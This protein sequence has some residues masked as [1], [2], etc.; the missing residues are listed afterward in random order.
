MNL[1]ELNDRLFIRSPSSSAGKHK[2]HD[3]HHHGSGSSKRKSGALCSKRGGG[4]LGGAENKATTP[5]ANSEKIL[6]LSSG[7]FVYSKSGFKVR[8]PRNASLTIQINIGKFSKYRNSLEDTDLR[9]QSVSNS[10]ECC[11]KRASPATSTGKS[12]PTNKDLSI[13]YDVRIKSKG[14][15]SNDIVT[16]R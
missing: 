1:L 7:L 13:Y 5:Y 8:M 15:Q 12:V 2:H 9:V 11:V 10:I 6:E 14:T 4:V 16:R 3:K